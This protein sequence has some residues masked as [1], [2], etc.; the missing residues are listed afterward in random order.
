MFSRRSWQSFVVMVLLSLGFLLGGL[1]AEAAGPLY[2]SSTLGD[3]GNTCALPDAPCKTITHA[4]SLAKANGNDHILVATGPYL[5]HVE[6][7]T[8]LS[9]QGG[10]HPMFQ[11]RDIES[12]PTVIEGDGTRTAVVISQP[13]L[14]DGF[15][16]RNTQAL[17]AG[18][19][20][21]SGTVAIVRATDVISNAASGTAGG[22]AATH[23][24][25]TVENSR[26]ADNRAQ[27]GGGL[28]FYQSV[29][30]LTNVW[31]E[32]N[33]VSESDAGIMLVESAAL[34]DGGVISGNV[35]GTYQGG[36]AIETGSTATLDH[37]TIRNNRARENGGLGVYQAT[38]TLNGGLVEGNHADL[39]NGGISIGESTAYLSDVRVSGNT[40]GDSNGGVGVYLST[41]HMQGG[42]IEM[43]HTAGWA[44]GM[45][46]GQSTAWITDVTIAGNSAEGGVGGMNI[47]D[48]SNADLR[49]VQVLAN[50]APQTGGVG[51]SQSAAVTF[52]KCAVL[53]NTASTDNAG[54]ISVSDGSHATLISTTV[55]SNSASG[56]SGGGMSVYQADATIEGSAFRGNHAPG[57]SALSVNFT[58]DLILRRTF[59]TGNVSGD[60]P[61]A[62]AFGRETT[63]QM[64]NAVIAGNTSDG[65][66]AA[67]QILGSGVITNVT[68]ADNRSSALGPPAFYA[69]FGHEPM[70]WLDVTNSIFYYNSPGN[71]GIANAENS[72][73]NV[74][75]CDTSEIVPGTGNIQAEPH[76][77]NRD[78]DDY[79]LTGASLCIDAGTGDG[80]PNVDITG[81]A[82]PVDGNHSGV[83]EWDIGAYEFQRQ[84]TY[85]PMVVKAQH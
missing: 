59:I 39:W 13:C 79:R 26:I 31:V 43:N 52:T 28:L 63:F 16:V 71:L 80:A 66:S 32:A 15:I 54:G 18:G 50:D 60:G 30:T 75:Y 25:V 36:I 12:Y 19:V 49:R 61:G 78:A 84:N 1:F 34:I 62:L 85:V 73:R 65:P 38:A 6:I 55:A 74:N 37:V 27:R 2:V 67:A 83:A 41:V 23:S 44:G 33:H 82:R 3:D 24:T 68:V 45:N 53:S 35:A 56:G 47:A 70:H 29:V 46:V 14:F 9:L 72:A 58:R 77:V 51:I 17:N 22:L 42:V 8:P 81:R 69:D 11:N 64:E 10:F 4:V 21:I 40:S 76:F 20:L 48:N 7:D 5:E 57:G